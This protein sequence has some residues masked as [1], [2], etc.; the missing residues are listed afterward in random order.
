MTILAF[1]SDPK[2]ARLMFLFMFIPFAALALTALGSFLLTAYRMHFYKPT[3]AVVTAIDRSDP[4]A[5]YH[6]AAYTYSGQNYVYRKKGTPYYYKEGTALTLMVNPHSPSKAY[7]SEK[8][9]VF[10]MSIGFSAALFGVFAFIYGIAYR[11]A[12]RRAR[13]MVE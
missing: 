7:N 6:E 12:L 3:E 8:P 5:V 9:Y 13:S 2:K 10:S 1:F 4:K 11:I